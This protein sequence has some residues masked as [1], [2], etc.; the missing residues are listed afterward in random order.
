MRKM[1]GFGSVS[2]L[3]IMIMIVVALATTSVVGINTS[4]AF[5]DT[6]D[7]SVNSNSCASANASANV[8]NTN[9]NINLNLN[10]NLNVNVNDVDVKVKNSVR[11]NVENNV[12]NNQGQAVVN[13]GN[14][15]QTTG[16][17]VVE[18]NR[19][20]PSSPGLMG[21]TNAIEPMMSRPAMS[22]LLDA[23]INKRT[24]SPA[25]LKAVASKTKNVKIY[26]AFSDL[27]GKGDISVYEIGDLPAGSMLG[28]T[29]FVITKDKTFLADVAAALLKAYEKGSDVVTISIGVKP[30]SIN[31]GIGTGSTGSGQGLSKGNPYG[32]AGTAGATLGYSQAYTKL[33]YKV[34]ITLY[35]NATL[36]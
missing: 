1:K 8:D 27:P 16:D 26:W 18:D 20:L 30:K 28:G 25:Y 14:T 32:F 31:I 9:N 35:A 3:A 7:H 23:I 13:A 34:I 19:E 29:A 2:L 22:D 17:I 15:A 6:V 33:L 4:Y 5:F 21:M 10:R 24:F 36:R 12:E 11:N